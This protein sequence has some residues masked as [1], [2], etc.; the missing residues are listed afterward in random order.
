MILDDI[1]VKV[2]HQEGVESTD[3]KAIYNTPAR[4]KK[5]LFYSHGTPKYLKLM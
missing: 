1:S 3:I 4:I 2:V 5:D